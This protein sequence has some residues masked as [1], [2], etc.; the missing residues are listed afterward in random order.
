MVTT[1]GDD[2]HHSPGGSWPLNGEGVVQL[3]RCGD[4]LVG[5]LIFNNGYGVAEFARNTPSVVFAQLSELFKYG[6][7][8]GP[9]HTARAPF[10]WFSFPDSLRATYFGGEFRL[11]QYAHWAVVLHVLLDQVRL[12]TLTRDRQE[13]FD[14][15]G[16]SLPAPQDLPTALHV[17]VEGEPRPFQACTTE[18]YFARC[19]IHRDLAFFLSID[20]K[21][22]VDPPMLVVTRNTRM[23]SERVRA[24]PLTA[25]PPAILY[26]ERGTNGRSYQRQ[27]P[28]TSSC[29]TRPA[30]QTDKAKSAATDLPPLDPAIKKAFMDRVKTIAAAGGA[31]KT[32]RRGC[33]SL[34]ERC[35]DKGI[36]VCGRGDKLWS[37]AEKAAGVKLPGGDRTRRYAA[38]TLRESGILCSDG[39]QDVFPVDDLRDPNSEYVRCTLALQPSEPANDSLLPRQSSG[40]S[41]GA[42]ESGEHDPLDDD[43]TPK[44][45]PPIQDPAIPS[46]SE[47]DGLHR[48]VGH[49]SGVASVPGPLPTT[50]VNSTQVDDA[51]FFQGLKDAQQQRLDREALDRLLGDAQGTPRKDSS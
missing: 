49:V 19:E 38:A 34:L 43:S 2:V 27:S 48:P 28:H 41:A 6:P 31:G 29:P 3:E 17:L 47:S 51:T 18:G 22:A 4:L 35:A 7:G 1:A 50:E 32:V 13:V 40:H 8:F 33:I 11:I 16:R 25:D 23:S 20:D 46:D 37:S 5:T 30:W 21:S 36:R 12:Y 24:I 44:S 39:E 9:S 45:A 15:L 10:R 26:V 42:E 14:C